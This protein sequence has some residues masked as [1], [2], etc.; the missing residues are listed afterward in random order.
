M[1]RNSEFF[2]VNYQG[3]DLEFEFY[4]IDYIFNQLTKVNYS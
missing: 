3:I 1:R 2:T 4:N